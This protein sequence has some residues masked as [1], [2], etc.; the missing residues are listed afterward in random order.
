VASID[1]KPGTYRDRKAM[2]DEAAA[3]LRQRHPNSDGVV[4]V[5][6]RARPAS[7]NLQ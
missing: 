2:A 5:F 6:V 7:P 4:R 3:V 1:G